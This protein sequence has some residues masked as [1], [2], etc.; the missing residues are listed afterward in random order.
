[1][2]AAAISAASGIFLFTA[3]VAACGGKAT[4]RDAVRGRLFDLGREMTRAYVIADDELNKPFSDRVIRPLIRRLTQLFGNLVP[5]RGK[6]RGGRERQKR[7]LQQAGWTISVEEYTTLQMILM[8]GCGLLGVVAAVLLKADL[9]HGALYCVGGMLAGY[10]GLRYVCTATGTKRKTA[11]EKQLPDMLDLLSISVAAGLGFE[12]AM[13]HI[14]ETMDGPLID[15]FA[16]AYREMSLGRSRKDALTLL[17]ER[18][19]VEDLSSVTS[20]LVQAG[21]L[22][23]PIRNVLQ[24]QAAAIRRA[25]RSRVQE[26]A[27]KVTTKMLLPMIGLIFPVLIIVLLGPSVITIIEQFG[28]SF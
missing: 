3:I 8:A 13:L 9:L 2:L 11:M 21:K 5:S 25:R 23:I 18:C 26:K 27:A 12:R 28:G 19:G 22:G 6:D 1:M 10:T 17:A 20:A 16:V 24:T 14:I 4:R 7:M 15:E